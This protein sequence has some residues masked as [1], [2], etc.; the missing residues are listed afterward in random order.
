[1]QNKGWGNKDGPPVKKNLLKGQI[2]II[3]NA[4]SEQGS[5]PNA[6]LT[7]KASSVSGDYHS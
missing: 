3:V 4:R 5:V 1:M 7:Y 2:I 6:L